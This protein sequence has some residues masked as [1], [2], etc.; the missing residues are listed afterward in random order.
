MLAAEGDFV[1]VVDTEWRDS[2]NRNRIADYV[3]CSLPYS[4]RHYNRAVTLE[5]QGPDLAPDEIHGESMGFLKVSPAAVPILK[6]TIE[7]ILSTSANRRANMPVLI[8]ELVAQKHSIRVV[9]TSGNWCDVDSIEDVVSA[10][11]F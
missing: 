5:R 4:R 1:V 8:N 11:T 9:Y 10:S 7:S 3:R 2:I 6:K